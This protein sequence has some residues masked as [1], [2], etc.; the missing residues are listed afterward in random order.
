M[1]KGR[2]VSGRAEQGGRGGRV[3]RES[4]EGK[5]REGERE[6]EVMEVVVEEE[7]K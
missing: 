4:G 7:E 5:Q 3:A 6:R 2:S 1:S